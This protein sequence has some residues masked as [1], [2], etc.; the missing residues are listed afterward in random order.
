ML[1][2]KL[3]TFVNPVLPHGFG[4]AV[5]NNKTEKVPYYQVLFHSDSKRNLREN[6]LQET[7]ANEN[8]NSLL[9]SSQKGFVDSTYWGCIRP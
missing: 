7:R 2:P 3:L 1:V 9:F 4:F 5:L 6:F 8:L